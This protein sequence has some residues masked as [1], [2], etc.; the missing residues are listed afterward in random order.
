[1]IEA[2]FVV[3]ESNDREIFRQQIGLHQVKERGRELPHREVACGPENDEDAR[4]GGTAVRFEISYAT[5]SQKSLLDRP[6]VSE[7]TPNRNQ[8]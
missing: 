7:G 5:G 4:T 6:I 3:S 1:M 2:K 8:Q